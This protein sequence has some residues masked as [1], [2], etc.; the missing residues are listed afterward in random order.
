MPQGTLR[1]RKPE[2]QNWDSKLIPRTGE[3]H[4]TD[5]KKNLSKG[6]LTYT[7]RK[8]GEETHNGKTKNKP[9]ELRHKTIGSANLERFW[10]KDHKIFGKPTR[11]R[12]TYH[13][14]REVEEPRKATEVAGRKLRSATTAMVGDDDEAVRACASERENRERG[15]RGCGR[16]LT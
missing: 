11:R 9:P 4:H 3:N 5:Q 15:R 10:K 16:V 14:E 8:W 2:H 1:K 6:S 7:P 13:G 12:Y